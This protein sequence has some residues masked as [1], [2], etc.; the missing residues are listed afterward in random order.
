MK[1]Y[2]ILI[3]V[4]FLFLIFS[5]YSYA[6]TVNEN[7]S[8]NVFRLHV[9]ANSDSKEDQDLKYKVRDKLIE[10]MK[11]ITSNIENKEEVINIAYNNIE[12]FQK[13]A[14]QVIKDNGFNYPVKVEIGNF[15]FP[16]KTYGDISF[17]SSFYD[18][19]KVEIG[20]ASGQNWWCVM[21]PPLCFVD[22]T[23]GVVPESSKEN[24]ETNLGQ[25]EYDIISNNNESDVIEFKF[26]IVEFFEDLG[27]KLANN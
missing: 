13:I 11:S 26:K 6:S 14:E 22:V 10:Y 27:I 3:L 7:L 19:L 24:L 23:S 12:N 4:L 2:I 20:N 18:A 8:D 9:I 15:S 16:T 5:A 1:K 17:P 25:E 21:F